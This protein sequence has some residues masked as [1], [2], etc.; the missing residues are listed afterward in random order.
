MYHNFQDVS[1]HPIPLW[2][3]QAKFGIY[4]HWGVYSVPACGPNGTWYPRFMYMPGTPQYE[5]HQTHYGPSHGYKDF[6]PM[7][8][9]EKFDPDEWAEL[10]EH[11]GAKFAGPVGEH[12]DGFSMWDTQYSKWNCCN[13]G[14]KRDVVGLLEQSIKRRGMK[15]FVALHH[16][17][18]WFF[19]PKSPGLDT[20]NPSY[21]G[22]Y[23]LPHQNPKDLWQS[24]F[25]KMEKPPSQLL[26]LWLNKTKEV[27]DRYSP[28]LLWFDSGLRF[29]QESYKEEM[30]CYYYNQ[31]QSWEK[32][33]CIIYKHNDLPPGCGL[34]D[35]EVGRLGELAYHNW[36]TDS[37]VD[38]AEGWS[39]I[40]NA[41]YK[42]PETLVH[43]L[44]D[45]VSKNGGLL[46]NV[47][48]KANGEIPQE[49]K[50]LLREM[51]DWLAVN[52]EGIYGTIPW[53]VY[54][55]GPSQ[56]TKQGP[57]GGFGEQEI[58]RFTKEDIRYTVKDNCLYAII[59]S[60]A[61][62]EV[63]LKKPAEVLYPDEIRVVTLLGSDRPCPYRLDS[64]G[65]MI[66]L[67]DTPP[68]RYAVT[69]KIERNIPPFP[70]K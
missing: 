46:L 50:Y 8:T 40:K 29:I 19:F 24:E 32:E 48:P 67:P 49:A 63:V 69:V 18:N 57:Y 61:C 36:I 65:L 31:E 16:A 35:I 17:E 12:H 27:I 9:G 56:F 62:G 14:P 41:S 52:G 53:A 22:L 66:T 58:V 51:G 55:E 1:A 23:S 11:S 2:L 34:V 64:R 15:F 6:I 38:S 7:F 47:G 30:A 20:S 3:K 28:D 60:P 33:V 25:E 10:F 5:Y 45:N 26:D 37:T 70:G 13:M 43:Y 59:L 54:G 4:T 42:Q 44:I 39:Y 68:C 21:S